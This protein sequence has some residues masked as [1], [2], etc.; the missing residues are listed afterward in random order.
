MRLFRVKGVFNLNSFAGSLLAK[1]IYALG[2]NM[3]DCLYYPNHKI[4]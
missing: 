4:A 3:H 1:C 2:T